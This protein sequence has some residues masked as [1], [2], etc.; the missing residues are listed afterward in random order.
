M[1]E[2]ARTFLMFQGQA[3]EA[4]RFYISTFTSASGSSIRRFGDDPAGKVMLA[5]L[6]IGGHKILLND[7]PIEHAFGFTPRVSIFLDCEDE[8]SVDRYAHALGDGGKTLMPVAN[9]GFSRRFA[10]VQDRF[11]VTWQLNLP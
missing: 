3:E 6:S 5:E 1:A 2:I 8:A 4:Y 9:Y 10:W 11:G 7:S